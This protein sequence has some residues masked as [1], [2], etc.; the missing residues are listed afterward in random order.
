MYKHVA[1]YHTNV[2]M[3][4]I[5]HFNMLVSLL[6]INHSHYKSRCTYMCHSTDFEQVNICIYSVLYFSHKYSASIAITMLQSPTYHCLQ[7]V[8]NIHTTSISFVHSIYS[9]NRL[10][11]PT[12][13]WQQSSIHIQ[14]I[15]FAVAQPGE[16]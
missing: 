7:N 3:Y 6:Q 13:S 10:I 4:S 14:C 15:S 5:C 9:T 8:N 12:I 1:L 2:C 16:F 11:R